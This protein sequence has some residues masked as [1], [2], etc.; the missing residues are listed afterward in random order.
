M[1][2]RYGEICT[3]YIRFVQIYILTNKNI[4]SKMRLRE[5]IDTSLLNVV[6]HAC[7]YFDEICICGL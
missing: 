7:G 1:T 5:S 6:I 3:G 2:S 4:C